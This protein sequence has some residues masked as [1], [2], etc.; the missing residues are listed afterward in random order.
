MDTTLSSI[1]ASSSHSER[2]DEGGGYTII[3]R[4]HTKNAR[5][6]SDSELDSNSNKFRCEDL[7]QNKAHYTG[8]PNTVQTSDTNPVDHLLIIELIKE[9]ITEKVIEDRATLRH[10][11]NKSQLGIKSTGIHRYQTARNRIILHIVEVNDIPELLKIEKLEDENE[12]WPIKC[13]RAQNNPGLSCLGV[14]KGIPVSIDPIKVKTNLSREG[15][16]VIKTSRITRKVGEDIINTRCIKVEFYGHTKPDTVPYAGFNKKV[17]PYIPPTYTLLC[18]RCGKGGHKA[19]QC[20]ARYKVCTIWASTEHT[21]D[22]CPKTSRRCS[23][24]KN[25][26][27]AN[28]YKCP[29]LQKERQITKIRLYENVPR[30]TAINIWD[31]KA[32][33]KQQNQIQAP[34][35]AVL[36]VNSIQY[37]TP[38]PQ[39]QNRNLVPPQYTTNF[40]PNFNAS[41]ISNPGMNIAPISNQTK[42]VPVHSIK[43]DLKQYIDEKFKIFEQKFFSKFSEMFLAMFDSLN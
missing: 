32:K 38:A 28:Y 31:E 42:Q 2:I 10:L 23:N 33:Q 18:H 11:L 3:N 25:E 6:L 21:R 13:Y 24:C 4:R 15:T 1:I 7:N 39:T 26:H 5:R 43:E 40:T 27:T 30:S 37:G 14:L 35:P 34:S 29:Y 12:S 36:P 17:H 20:K 8:N 22:T 9:S 41:N 19:D 16:N